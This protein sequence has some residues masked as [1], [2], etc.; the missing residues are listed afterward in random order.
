MLEVVGCIERMKIAA[1]FG[2]AKVCIR[3]TRLGY[4]FGFP[5]IGYIQFDTS[6]PNVC[7]IVR[8]LLREPKAG[9]VSVARRLLQA[10]PMPG[11]YRSRFLSHSEP[12]EA[13][14]S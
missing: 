12:T 13:G 2:Y 4:P 1:L 7:Y 9:I 8:L 10:L 5:I 14:S 3:D 11:L 6:R